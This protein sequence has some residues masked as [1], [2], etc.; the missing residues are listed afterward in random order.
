MKN[1]TKGYE[2]RSIKNKTKTINKNH[3]QKKQQQRNRTIF[4]TYIIL[5]ECV[6]VHVRVCV[7]VTFEEMYGG[8]K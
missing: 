7:C 3:T 5:E 4:K 1:Y 8:R 2:E 6:R